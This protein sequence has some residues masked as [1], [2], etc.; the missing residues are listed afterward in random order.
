MKYVRIGIQGLLAIAVGGMGIAPGCGNSTESKCDTGQVLENNM[1]VA[2]ASA[3]TGG[4]GTTAGAGGS[5]VEAEAS[6]PDTTNTVGAADAAAPDGGG[7]FGTP[8]LQSG[9]SPECAAPAPYCGIQPGKTTGYCTALDCKTNPTICP[10]KWTC[11]DVS[12]M[13]FCMAPM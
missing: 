4:S 7:A 9:Q 3:G 1:C 13:N 11:F 6:T 12:V 2:A 10:D 8:C 5:A